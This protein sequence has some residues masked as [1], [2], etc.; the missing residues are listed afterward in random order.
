MMFWEEATVFEVIRPDAHT[1]GNPVEAVNID[2]NVNGCGGVGCDHSLAG[3]SLEHVH[4]KTSSMPIFPL[5]EIPHVFT[6][7]EEFLSY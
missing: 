2:G 5:T 3:F 7:S 4:R 1:G 6:K